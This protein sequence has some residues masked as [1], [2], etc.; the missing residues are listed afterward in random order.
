MTKFTALLAASVSALA[1][2]SAAHAADLIIEEPVAEPII[3]ATGGSWDGFYVGVFGGWA[4]GQVVDEDGDDFADL[5]DNWFLGV[6]AGANF[7]LTDGIVVGVVG[8]LEYLGLETVIDNGVGQAV[9]YDLFWAGSLRGR[10]GFDGGQW[11]PYLTA[12]I[13]AADAKLEASGNVNAEDTNVHVGW[14]AGVGV[15]FAATENVSIDLLYRYTDYGTQE[16]TLGALGSGDIGFTTHQ[17]SAGLNW[18]F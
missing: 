10:I 14:T 6:N 2:A 3:E 15:E 17:V 13:A 9:S 4:D 5:D 16:Y 12:G 8:D 18:K 1:F 11:M 7:T